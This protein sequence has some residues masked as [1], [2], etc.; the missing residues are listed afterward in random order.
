MS[1]EPY[2]TH[3][4]RES[5]GCAKAALIRG[6]DPGTTVDPHSEIRSE[7]HQSRTP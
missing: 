3:L 4:A 1:T 6:D 2:P 5:D 7:R